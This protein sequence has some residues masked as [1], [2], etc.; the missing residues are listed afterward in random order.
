MT[1]EIFPAFFSWEEHLYVLLNSKVQ[2]Y[3]LIF[4]EKTAQMPQIRRKFITI[5]W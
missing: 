2:I 1:L 3:T 4:F 5:S